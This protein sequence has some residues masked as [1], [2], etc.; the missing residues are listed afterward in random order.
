[1]KNIPNRIKI[2][3]FIRV[4]ISDEGEGNHFVFFLMENR[5]RYDAPL[6]LTEILDLCC[7]GIDKDTLL[8]AM[9]E[10]FEI[11]FEEAENEISDLLKA[12]VLLEESKSNETIDYYKVWYKHNWHATLRYMISSTKQFFVDLGTNKKAVQAKTYQ[13]YLQEGIPDFY[14]EGDKNLKTIELPP[15]NENT[16]NDASLYEV[17]LKRRT[18]RTYTRPITIEELG[19]VLGNAFAEVKNCR[20]HQIENIEN[21]PEALYVSLFTPFELK[22]VVQDVTGLNSGVYRYNIQSHTLTLTS[23]TYNKEDLINAALGQKFLSN[24][25]VV[26]LITCV[27][28]RSYFRYRHEQAYRPAMV[29][30]GELAHNIILNATQFDIKS[31]QSPGMDDTT[32]NKVFGLDGIDEMPFYMVAIGK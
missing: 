31:F 7:A 23:E 6:K 26:M 9:C 10:K 13:Q 1:M 27:F 32:V 18:G 28:E 19:Q 15:A 29:S 25:A 21:N 12:R 11:D 17:L 2:N 3:P 5:I 20:E 16:F 30:A 14:Y 22:L 24:A 4:F 8:S